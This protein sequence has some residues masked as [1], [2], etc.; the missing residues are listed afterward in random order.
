MLLVFCA[1]LGV[2]ARAADAPHPMP[3]ARDTVIVP[4]DPRKPLAGQVPDRV[5]LDGDRFLGLWEA[6]KQNRR[7]EKA[8]VAAF[9]F[10]L[11][12][13]RYEGRIEEK[14]V[15]FTATLELTTFNQPWQRVPLPFRDVQI[16]ELALDGRPAPFVDGALLIEHTGKH[17]VTV[18][19]EIPLAAGAREFAW[20]IPPSAATRLALT[21]QET[22][23]QVQVQPDAGVIE[24]MEGGVVTVTAALGTTASV[25]VALVERGAAVRI[26]EAGL[27]EIT[28]AVAVSPA[29]ERAVAEVNASFPG[30]RQDR[31]SVR[32]SPKGAALVALDAPGLRSWGLRDDAAGQVLEFVLNEP[33]KERYKFTVTVERAQAASLP[34]DSSAPWIDAGGARREYVQELYTAAGFAV[35]VTPSASLRQIERNLKPMNE[36]APVGAWAGGEPLKYHVEPAATAHEARVDYVYQVNRRT[37]ELIASLKLRARGGPLFGATLTLPAGFDVQA[38]DSERLQD[39]WRDGQKL[40]LRF[41]GATP[42]MTPL[43]VYLVREYATAPQQLD[44]QPLALDGFA[45]VAGEAVIAAHKGVDA[46][47]TLA[48]VGG[49]EP[50]REVDSAKAAPDFQILPPL[51]RKRGFAFKNQSFSGQVALAP[52]PVRLNA[53]W[54]MHAQAFETWASLSLKAQLRLRQGSIER[55]GFSLPASLPEARVSGGEVR[56]TRS[57]IEGDRRIY[58]VAF[59]NDVYDA[60]DF[61]VDV[62][63]TMAG[64]SRPDGRR[65]NELVLPAPEFP[66]SQFVTGYVLADNASEYE[67]KL[68]TDGVEQ[69]AKAEIPWLPSLTKS[70]GVFRV[71]PAWKIALTMERLQKAESRTAFCAWAEMTTALRN[72]GT[73][74][75]KAVW[76]LQNRSLQFLPVRLPA[77]AVLVGARVAGQGVRADAG[78]ADGRA[79]ILVPLIRTKPGD[80]SY[81]VEVVWRQQGSRLANRDRRKFEGAE[82]PGITVEQTFWS[83]WLPQDR[84]L[85]KKDG[86]MEE[87][88]AIQRE[89]EKVKNEV[90]ELSVLNGI[91]NDEKV[92]QE[93]WFNAKR[94]WDAVYERAKNAT[95]DNRGALSSRR[96]ELAGRKDG[97]DKLVQE[98]LA[99]LSDSNAGVRRQLEQLAEENKKIQDKMQYRAQG[100]TVPAAS[101]QNAAGIGGQQQLQAP[102]NAAQT[103]LLGNTYTGSV[104]VNA[105]QMADINGIVQQQTGATQAQPGQNARWL[106]NPGPS[107]TLVQTAVPEPAAGRVTG[108]TRNLYLNDNIVLQQAKGKEPSPTVKTTDGRL[109]MDPQ[110]VPQR[111]ADLPVVPLE[112]TD[113]KPA[114]PAGEEKSVDS[115]SELNATRGLNVARGNRLQQLEQA[116]STPQ[117]IENVASR[118]PDEQPAPPATPRP[119][120][121]GAPPA[122][123][124]AAAPGGG[125]ARPALPPSSSAPASPF[126][127]Q[128]GMIRVPAGG[129][130]GA[131]VLQPQGRLSLNV[132]FP[133]EGRAYHF[134]KVKATAVLELSIA[135]PAFAQRWIRALIFS[136]LAVALWFLTRVVAARKRQ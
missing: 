55:T 92:S 86:N 59:Q 102:A 38:V 123:A 17:T 45:R 50:A 34:A 49:A 2:T 64:R 129:A 42:E 80:V 67:M 117:Q 37:I 47:L 25:R 131:A 112:V 10:A 134:Q 23:W 70:A 124:T 107:T 46:T 24:R 63:V 82:L 52:L 68:A 21:V 4:Y 114:G 20:G 7:P 133:T 3:A 73:E 98:R 57:R 60:V 136:T 122:P 28:S 75:H 104:T 115:I 41:H 56:E 32:L 26:A 11:G 85:T 6:A 9:P 74:W 83:V 95:V 81:D 97:D 31:F 106:A 15:A 101:P 71:Q 14:R 89:I 105:G 108:D 58:D 110:G 43:V 51:E 78:L 90:D 40:R 87:V 19:F 8:P 130:G 39:W 29:F 132:D 33:V 88:V 127:S 18:T 69:V 79:V 16:R 118:K 135:D 72:D 1:V 35:K 36:W 100:N 48:A 125:P 111:T 66:G 13:A 94:N 22:R 119:S 99:Q 109:N 126:Q 116:R 62:D 65:V 53:T 91:L 12:A 27:V 96:Y 54:V 93:V 103:L 77:G 120:E 84:E 30:A 5:Y 61:T 121:P 113:A 76:H 128:P 44:V